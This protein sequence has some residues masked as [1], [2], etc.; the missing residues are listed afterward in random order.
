MKSQPLQ[1]KI[2]TTCR[3]LKVNME[4]DEMYLWVL[5]EMIDEVDK[6]LSI[7]LE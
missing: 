7:V 1:E 5:R 4:P 2:E 3:T 6:Q